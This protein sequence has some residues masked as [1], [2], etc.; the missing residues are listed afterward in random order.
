MITVNGVAITPEQINAEVQYHPAPALLEAKYQA[1]QALVVR[2][3]LAQRAAGLGLVEGDFSDA[4]IDR[5]LQQEIEVPEPTAEETRRY[6]R[7][8]EKQFCTD[9]LFEVSHI[10]YLAPPED[11]EAR[12]AA[13]AR[14]EQALAEITADPALFAGIAR[15]DSACSSGREGGSLGQIAPGQT[16]PAFEE[17]LQK[18]KAGEIS[19]A[20]VASEVGYHLIHLH[21]RVESEQMP[22]EAV[23]ARI[24]KH[25]RAQSWQRAVSQYI[26]L[27]AG[28]A[29][30]IGFR[31][32]GAETPLVQ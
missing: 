22:Y 11:A 25:L 5:L 17:A 30:I 24:G 23:A 19:A 28:E 10:L 31:L 3:L 29:E 2:E 27:L 6:Y 14:A 20:P 32:A 18:M 4:V 8:N 12:R 7:N 13:L 15:R 21:R 26:Q 16:L 1:M 9:P